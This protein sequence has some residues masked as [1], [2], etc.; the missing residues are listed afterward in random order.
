MYIFNY[1][2]G[3]Q[4]QL[5]EHMNINWRKDTVAHNWQQTSWHSQC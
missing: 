1:E 2:S 5:W 4:S 3:L